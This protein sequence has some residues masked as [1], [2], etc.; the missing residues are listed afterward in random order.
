MGLCKGRRHRLLSRWALAD[1]VKQ[2]VAPLVLQKW[3]SCAAMCK[4]SRVAADFVVFASVLHLRGSCHV[5]RVSSTLGWRPLMSAPATGL[6]HVELG[7]AQG[8]LA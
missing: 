8:A 1:V 4:A 2:W 5:F 6:L 3:L 7:G